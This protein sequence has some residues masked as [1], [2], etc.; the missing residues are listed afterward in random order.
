MNGTFSIISRLSTFILGLVDGLLELFSILL[1]LLRV[2][3][4][5]DQFERLCKVT[6]HSHLINKHC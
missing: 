2:L 5:K 6:L 3:I 1:I 4:L